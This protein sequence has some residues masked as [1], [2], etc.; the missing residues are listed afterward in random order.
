[1]AARFTS[2]CFWLLYRSVRRK[3]K[4]NFG[5]RSNRRFQKKHAAR[6]AV[7]L[8]QT[9][10]HRWGVKV[11]GEGAGGNPLGVRFFIVLKSQDSEDGCVISGLVG[12]SRSLACEADGVLTRL[13]WAPHPPLCCPPRP[14][15]PHCRQKQWPPGWREWGWSSPQAGRRNLLLRSQTPSSGSWLPGSAPGS[16]CQGWFQTLWNHWWWPPC[17]Q[18]R[19]GE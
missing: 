14:S 3:S 11:K 2:T 9:R 15:C 17:C 10:A 1:M 16:G 13:H 18:D 5:M 8:P 19:G 4:T 6:L 7:P 12:V